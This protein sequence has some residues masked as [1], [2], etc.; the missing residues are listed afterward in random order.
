MSVARVY[1]DQTLFD[2][3]TRASMNVSSSPA[4]LVISKLIPADAG[5]RTT[6]HYSKN[7]VNPTNKNIFNLHNETK[8]KATW[9]LDITSSHGTGL[10][11]CRVDFKRSPTKHALWNL[12]VIG[13]NYSSNI[14]HSYKLQSIWIKLG[15]L[16]LHNLSGADTFLLLVNNF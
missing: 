10:Y 6:R 8:C 2:E 14:V 11:K 7:P 16:L 1:S 3:P 13:K 4:A 5:I 15:E 12:T 9:L